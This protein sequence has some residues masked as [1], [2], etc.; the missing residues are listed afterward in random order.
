MEWL[1]ILA[2]II[3][4]LWAMSVFGAYGLFAVLGALI[5]FGYLHSVKKHGG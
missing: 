5:V 4:G 1:A 3:G 2:A